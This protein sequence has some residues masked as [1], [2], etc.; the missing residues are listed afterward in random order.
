MRKFSTALLVSATVLAT[1]AL[2]ADETERG[3]LLSLSCA[4]CHGTMGKSPGAIPPLAGRAEG[5]LSATLID[6]KSGRQEGTVMNR[7]ARGYSEAELKAI[8]KFLSSVK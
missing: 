6:F 4:A 8:A 1:P 3:M 2:A 7:I 5:Y